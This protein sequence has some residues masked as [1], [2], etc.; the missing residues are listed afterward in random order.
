MVKGDGPT[1]LVDKKNT[2]QRHG[3]E[4]IRWDAKGSVETTKPKGNW[5]NQQKPSAA[6]CTASREFLL[7]QCSI[8]WIRCLLGDT[9]GTWPAQWKN[10]VYMLVI[11]KKMELA[12]W[13]VALSQLVWFF[14]CSAGHQWSRTRQVW[15]REK[16]TICSRMT[17]S[18]SF[19]HQHFSVTSGI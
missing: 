15:D 9:V 5:E 10:Q 13:Y 16:A 17:M 2:K 1:N 11:T 19:C 18:K 4:I 6:F 12:T 7:F 8:T 14:T 3:A